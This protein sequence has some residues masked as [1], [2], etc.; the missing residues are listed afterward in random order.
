MSAVV[1]KKRPLGTAVCYGAAAAAA[2]AAVSAASQPP[3]K[4]PVAPSSRPLLSFSSSSKKQ[5][6]L[7]IV[8]N[9]SREACVAYKFTNGAQK[10]L[11]DPIRALME[12]PAS[13]GVPACHWF[14]ASELINT[15]EISSNAKTFTQ[16]IELRGIAPKP[17]ELSD[18]MFAEFS[19]DP[20]IYPQEVEALLEM[21]SMLNTSAVTSALGTTVLAF[22]ATPAGF[23]LFYRSIGKSAAD[24][25]PLL[26]QHLKNP[27]PAFTNRLG[28]AKLVARRI[29]MRQVSTRITELKARGAALEW[30]EITGPSLIEPNYEV[31]LDGLDFSAPKNYPEPLYAFFYHFEAFD[32]ATF[33]RL[34]HAKQ[35]PVLDA[36]EEAKL[37]WG[38]GSRSVDPDADTVSCSSIEEEGDDN[39]TDSNAERFYDDGD[40]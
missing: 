19:L 38:G 12:L 9:R 18:A 39:D 37:M 11:V 13:R 25:I 3:L 7:Q 27:P 40:F 20:C 26:N 23:S 35:A 6:F 21:C 5:E 8:R 29:D 33:L 32:Y 30:V 1:A 17:F 15:V 16:I 14:Y 24:L 22:V 10:G 4:R 36:L 2:A 28:A 34:H 31:H